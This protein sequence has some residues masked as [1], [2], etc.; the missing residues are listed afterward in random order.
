MHC[1]SAVNARL[2]WHLGFAF[3]TSFVSFLVGLI[4]LVGLSLGF[5]SP[6][7]FDKVTLS[8]V[9]WWAWLGGVLGT[10]GLT[11]NVLISPKLGGV[12]TAVMPILGQ[13]LMGLLIDS[14]GL[15]RSVQIPFWAAKLWGFCWFWQAYLWRLSCPNA[16][17]LPKR[18]IRRGFGGAVACLGRCLFCL[19]CILCQKLGQDRW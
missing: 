7:W 15:L 5:G 11:A 10:V 19:G 2:R 4:F 3:L 13:V 14:F 12:Q 18:T 9:P 1:L 8:A 6:L 16:G 17:N